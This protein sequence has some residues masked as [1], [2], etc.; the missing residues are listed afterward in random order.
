M[1]FNGSGTFIR[2]KNW[3][4]NASLNINIL[5]DLMDLDTQDIANGLSLCITRDGQGV[6][7]NNISWNN[8]Q[9]NNLLAPSLALDASNKAYVDATNATATSI[10]SMGGYRITNLGAPTLAT[11]AC[12]KGYVDTF[13]APLASPTFTGIIT[14]PLVPTTIGSAVSKQYVDAASGTVGQWQ[15]SPQTYTVGTTIFSPVNFFSYR[16]KTGVNTT[17]DPSIDNTNWAAISSQAIGSII[18]LQSIYGAM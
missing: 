8:F 13:Y 4:L 1:S 12:T 11:D 5:P 18:Y 14:V 16:N 7:T 6:P 17:S 10:R 2:L 9:I 3:V 15:P